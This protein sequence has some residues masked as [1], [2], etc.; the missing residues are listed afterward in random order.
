MPDQPYRF[1]MYNYL[2][3][4]PGSSHHSND[5]LLA[6]LRGELRGEP[7]SWLRGSLIRCCAGESLGT[8][9]TTTTRLSVNRH[10]FS[11][12]YSFNGTTWSGT[13][14]ANVKLSSNPK[15]SSNPNIIAA[16]VSMG[17]GLLPNSPFSFERDTRTVIFLPATSFTGESF[18]SGCLLFFTLIPDPGTSFCCCPSTWALSMDTMR[19]SLPFLFCF[20][21]TEL[22]EELR[23]RL[24]LPEGG[25][26]EELEFSDRV[27]GVSLES[28]AGVWDAEC[29]FGFFFFFFASCCSSCLGS[30]DYYK[31]KSWWHA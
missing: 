18:V 14:A 23:L 16:L 3:S 15:S 20:G 13:P 30:K 27:L 29:C 24:E 31:G 1:T 5:S 12:G 21:S 10:I 28:W 22:E 7:D 19:A 17:C 26:A 4:F 25:I 8:R 9:L 6:G 2:G 11:P